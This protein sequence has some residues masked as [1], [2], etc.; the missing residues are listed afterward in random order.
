[1]D[2]NKAMVTC[3]IALC[4]AAYLS[5]KVKYKHI[6]PVPVLT[7]PT[8]QRIYAIQGITTAANRSEA[9]KAL[10][11]DNDVIIDSLYHRMLRD[12]VFLNRVANTFINIPNDDLLTI[13]QVK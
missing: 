11:I 6:E 2:R 8:A 4:F 3:V 7:D 10:S 13:K 12:S 1:M 9:I 5:F